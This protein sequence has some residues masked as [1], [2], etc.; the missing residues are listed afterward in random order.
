VELQFKDWVNIPQET[1]R[2]V[3]NVKQFKQAYQKTVPKQEAFACHN[4]YSLKKYQ[5]CLS[6]KSK[7]LA[8]SR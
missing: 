5:S 8:T 4:S 7:L 6:H 1:R 3:I 2:A